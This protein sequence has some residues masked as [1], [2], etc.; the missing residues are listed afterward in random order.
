MVRRDEKG[1][2]GKP[3]L[4]LPLVFALAA[5]AS[6]AVA[7]PARLQ[8]LESPGRSQLE[9]TLGRSIQSA[10][11][12]LSTS[13]CQQVFSDFRDSA[14]QTLQQNLNAAGHTGEAHLALMLFY[15][16]NGMSRCG[17]RSVLASTSPG[18]RVIYVCAA[19]FLEKL[20]RD[21]GLGAPLI[22][23][24]QLHSLGLTE[25]PP[26]SREITAQVISRCGR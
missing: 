4:L 19:Q 21:P 15:N 1:R 20:R 9:R 24:E 23:H 8:L 10:S 14:G 5:P 7:E 11:Q 12:K 22:I 6:I 16:G 17:E 3:G 13:A 25:N 2:P 26:D 18:S